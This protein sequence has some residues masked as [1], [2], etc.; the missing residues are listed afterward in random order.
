M[1]KNKTVFPTTYTNNMRIQGNS[2]KVTGSAHTSSLDHRVNITSPYRRM[3]AMF[4][5]IMTQEEVDYLDS[6]H[7]TSE[8]GNMDLAIETYKHLIRRKEREDENE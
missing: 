3:N 1:S 4:G 5:L 8:Q 2:A 7:N 6:L